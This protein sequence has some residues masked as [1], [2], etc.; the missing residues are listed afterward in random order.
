M[1]SLCEATTLSVTVHVGSLRGLLLTGIDC[2]CYYYHYHYQIMVVIIIVY[3]LYVD[4]LKVR[5]L[6]E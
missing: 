6:L 4:V 2:Y 1:R 5:S 3:D